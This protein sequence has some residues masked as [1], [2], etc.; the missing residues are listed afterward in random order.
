MEREL[1]FIDDDEGF[2]FLYSYHFQSLVKKLC[3]EPKFF[4]SSVKAM[5]YLKKTS[6]ENK[7][8]VIVADY[9]MPDI[10]GIEILNFI[11]KKKSDALGILVSGKA[12]GQNLNKNGYEF[13]KKP[14]DFSKLEQRV[15]EGFA[16]L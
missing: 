6:F 14:L 16:S 7:K 9:F 8:I 11:T 5:D 12:K 4:N 10:S 15:L 1:V 3:L 13:F 2:E